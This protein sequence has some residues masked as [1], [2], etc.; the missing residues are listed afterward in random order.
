M[1]IKLS[2]SCKETYGPFLAVTL[3][4]PRPP[5]KMF[6]AALASLE[7]AVTVAM[8]TVGSTRAV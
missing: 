6:T 8:L 4:V 2:P 3:V 1:S 7:V 5:E